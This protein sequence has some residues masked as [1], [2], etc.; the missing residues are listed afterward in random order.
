M[1][2]VF[3]TVSEQSLEMNPSI[4]KPLI[5]P[6]DVAVF[7]QAT[8]NSR[9]AARVANAA[10]VEEINIH[11]DVEVAVFSMTR[12]SLNSY[13]DYKIGTAEFLTQTDL[14]ASSHEPLFKKAKFQPEVSF[15]EFEWN[16]SPSVRHQI[17]G[18][19]GF[20]LGQLSW[21]TDFS[22]K[23]RR[24]LSLYS[25]FGINIY[26]TFEGLRNPSSQIPHVRSDIKST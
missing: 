1:I 7:H 20:Y 19:E 12:Q 23:F 2:I 22:L 24:N 15:P 8:T 14:T 18:P 17:G 9:R 21:Q 25:S 3:F 16:M 10:I 5:I 11:S 13:L 4:Y 6:M 26:D